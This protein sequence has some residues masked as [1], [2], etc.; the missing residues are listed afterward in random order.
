[1]DE[2]I[3]TW[4]VAD[5]FTWSV[6]IFFAVFCAGLARECWRLWRGK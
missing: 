2:P 3:F 5:V 4:T 1:M 6:I